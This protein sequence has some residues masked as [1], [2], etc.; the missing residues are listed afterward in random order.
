MFQHRSRIQ[1]KSA[2]AQNSRHGLSITKIIMKIGSTEL[3]R[4]QRQHHQ[5]EDPEGLF[6]AAS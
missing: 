3:R 5:H 2:S 4:K 1:P 6:V